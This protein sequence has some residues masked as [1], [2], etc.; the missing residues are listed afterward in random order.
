MTPLPQPLLD[1][2]AALHALHQRRHFSKYLNPLNALEA[3]KR[4][5]AGAPAPPFAYHPLDWADEELRMLDA[6]RPPEDHPMGALLAHAIDRN[7]LLISALAER[8]TEAF[9]ALARAANWYPNEDLLIQAADQRPASDRSR[10]ILGAHELVLEL[11]QALDARGLRSWRLELD[12][13]MSARVLVDGPKRLL[14]VNSRAR[15]RE[16]D[17]RKLIV[18]EIEVHALRSANGAQQSLK[19]FASGTPDSLITEEGLALYAEYLAGVQSPGT[20]WRQG[21]VVQAVDWA[22]TMGFR[23]LYD[24]ISDIGG[25]ALAWGITQR[26]KRGLADPAAPGV[27]AKDVVYFVG[28]HQVR[29]WLEAGNPI[30]NLYVGKVA[31]DDPVDEWIAEGWLVPQPVPALFRRIS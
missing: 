30:E 16:R 21:L 2:D 6:L 13:V 14:R 7:R 10:F 11:R 28:F 19:L 26:I 3:R 5:D 22:R 12:P 20:N 8:T 18:H 23:E 1:A 15:F 24:R 31:I 9:D 4:F 29:A 27:Y 17:V 25:R